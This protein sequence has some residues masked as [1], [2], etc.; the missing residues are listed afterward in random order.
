MQE[1]VFATQASMA[2]GYME[3]NIPIKHFQEDP[4]KLDKSKLD[5]AQ[6]L[7]QKPLGTK[8]FVQGPFQDLRYFGRGH[9]YNDLTKEY[10]KYNFIG[11]IADGFGINAVM[12]IMNNKQ[13][14]E[15]DYVNMN[16]IYNAPSVNDM[17]YGDK[18]ILF[19]SFSYFNVWFSFDQKLKTEDKNFMEKHNKVFYGEGLSQEVLEKTMPMPVDDVIIIVAV[20][21]LVKRAKTLESLKILG[22]ESKHIHE[23]EFEFQGDYEVF[24][25]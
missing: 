10:L 8:V 23:V 15:D 17:Y 9:F 24:A 12:N 22:F 20:P 1:L 25:E 5:F 11:A 14:D 3:T 4:K 2:V 13:E 21:D 6:V 7:Y 18:L 19:Q 16:L